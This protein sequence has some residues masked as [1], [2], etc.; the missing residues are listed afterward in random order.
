MSM[1]KRDYKPDPSPKPYDPGKK[2]EHDYKPDPNPPS[3]PTSPPPD[4]QKPKK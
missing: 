1:K 4:T 3:P 2:I